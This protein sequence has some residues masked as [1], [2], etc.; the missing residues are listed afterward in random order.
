MEKRGRLFYPNAT[1]DLLTIAITELAHIRLRL[2]PAS[3]KIPVLFSCCFAS[4]CITQQ[5]GTCR[6]TLGGRGLLPDPLFLGAYAANGTQRFP[7]SPG[8][9]LHHA[10][11]KQ[12]MENTRGYVERKEKGSITSENSV[13]KQKPAKLHIPNFILAAFPLVTANW[14]QIKAANRPG[15]SALK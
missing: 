2:E 5:E 1:Q 10:P 3:S 13:W 4:F 12:G 14:T 9:S 8:D 11:W 7:L 6:L 15:G